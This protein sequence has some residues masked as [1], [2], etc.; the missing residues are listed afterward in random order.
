MYTKGFI[1]PRGAI[2][3]NASNIFFPDLWVTI[4]IWG[5]L[6]KCSKIFYH[7]VVKYRIGEELKRSESLNYDEWRKETKVY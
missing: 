3:I 2:I 7:D 4:F 5:L 6:Y 1:F